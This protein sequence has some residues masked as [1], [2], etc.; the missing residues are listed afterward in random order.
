MAKSTFGYTFA[1]CLGILDLKSR[2]IEAIV[3]IMFVHSTCT[4]HIDVYSYIMYVGP[5]GTCCRE[6]CY[7]V[8]MCDW[9]LL[10]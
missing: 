7:H 3:M 6:P 2:E 8:C 10:Y 9:A 5:C 4:L 1:Q